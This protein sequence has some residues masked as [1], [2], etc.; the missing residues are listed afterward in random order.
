MEIDE[1]RMQKGFKGYV[2]KFYI[3]D[4]HLEKIFSDYDLKNNLEKYQKFVY[5]QRF[6]EF[7]PQFQC[8]TLKF[9]VCLFSE[10]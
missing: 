1:M 8:F 2:V 6:D 7:S 10:I 4:F 5:F 3:V 9:K